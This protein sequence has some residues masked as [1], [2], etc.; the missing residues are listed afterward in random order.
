MANEDIR[1]YAKYKGVPF[2][3]IAA[4][5]KISEP[6]LTRRLRFELDDKEKSKYKHII[7]KIGGT[8]SANA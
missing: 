2:W 3:K 4:D 8:D 5:M 1:R 6:T 7:E